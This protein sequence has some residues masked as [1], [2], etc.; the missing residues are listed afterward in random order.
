M[1]EAPIYDSANRG[2]IALEEL[3][4]LLRYRH[5]VYQLVRRD[6]VS[7]Y[8]RSI[9]GVAWTMLNPLGMMLVLTIVF[10]Q[11]FGRTESYPAFVLSG[12]IAWNFFSQTTSVGMQQ[13][14]WGSGLMSRIYIPRTAFPVSAIFTGIINLLLSLIPLFIVMLV[15]NVPIHLTV[16]FIPFSVII[17]AAFSLGVSMLLSSIAI[18]FP[19]VAEIY[20]IVLRAWMFLTPIIYPETIYPETYRFWILNLNPM[21]HLVKTFRPPIYVG[22]LTAP[23]EILVAGCIAIVALFS[24]WVIYAKEAEQVAYQN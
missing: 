23:L 12:I 11:V 22:V 3:R 14:L 10:S 13:L 15:T 18:H 9:L 17:L 2:P 7:R 5:L 24:G 6:I 16:L 20:R 19:D 1:V 21:Y 8:K 4:E